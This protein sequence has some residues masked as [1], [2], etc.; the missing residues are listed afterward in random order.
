MLILPQL[1]VTPYPLAG[2]SDQARRRMN[3]I[4][5]SGALLHLHLHIDDASNCTCEASARAPFRRRP[6][7][8]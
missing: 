3:G 1:D 4:T 7:L 5:N 8:G 6:R 2:L